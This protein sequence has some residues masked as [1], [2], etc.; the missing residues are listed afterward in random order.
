ME[1][2]LVKAEN[3]KSPNVKTDDVKAPDEETSPEKKDKITKKQNQKVEVV[4]NPIPPE[5]PEKKLD[6]KVHENNATKEEKIEDKPIPT[7]K[8]GNLSVSFMNE[9]NESVDLIKTET[10]LRFLGVGGEYNKKY[11]TLI[12]YGYQLKGKIGLPI[13]KDEYKVPYSHVLRGHF[14]LSDVGKIFSFY[15]GGEHSTLYSVNIPTFGEGLQLI[16][17]TILWAYLGTEATFN[18]EKMKISYEFATSL[19]VSNKI[20]RTFQASRQ[21]VTFWSHLFKSIGLGVSGSLIDAAG[22]FTVSAQN[23]ELLMTYAL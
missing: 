14:F 7:K 13:F 20:N 5:N 10:N 3:V 22:D 1:D 6:K 23:Y 15:G 4:N 8:W 2:D 17:N 12:K 16:D 19:G 21:T 11:L 9:Y 18:D